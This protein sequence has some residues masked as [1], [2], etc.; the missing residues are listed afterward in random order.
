MASF[1]GGGCMGGRSMGSMNIWAT[2]RFRIIGTVLGVEGGG[3]RVP[4]SCIWGL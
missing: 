2:L 3:V 1:E 4:Y